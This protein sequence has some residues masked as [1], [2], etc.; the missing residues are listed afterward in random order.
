VFGVLVQYWSGVLSPQAFGIAVREPALVRHQAAERVFKVLASS[1]LFAGSAEAVC[2]V[3]PNPRLRWS[4]D[5][6]DKINTVFLYIVHAP[7]RFDRQIKVGKH[8]LDL[9]FDLQNLAPAMPKENNVVAVPE[10]PGGLELLLDRPIKL[11]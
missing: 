2:N 4:E 3:L 7:V 10:V 8:R 6:P 5:V 11:V 9:R 1:Q